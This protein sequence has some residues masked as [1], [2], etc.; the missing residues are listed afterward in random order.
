MGP[1]PRF[2]GRIFRFRPLEWAALR[3]ASPCVNGINP[4]TKRAPI[5]LPKR[6]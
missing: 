4:R 3:A 5:A 1:T 2:C 6:I